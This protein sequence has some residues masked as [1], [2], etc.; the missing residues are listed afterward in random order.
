MGK[1]LQIGIA[2]LP[3]ILGGVI[4]WRAVINT[5]KRNPAYAHFLR[6]ERLRDFLGRYRFSAAYQI[7]SWVT[8]ID[9]GMHL[10]RKFQEEEQA[11]WKSGGLVALT[12]WTPSLKPLEDVRTPTRFIKV[13][14]RDGDTISASCLPENVADL[15]SVFCCI[16]NRVPI[17]PLTR[18]AGFNVEDIPCRLPDGS[19]VELDALQKWLNDGVAAGWSV[20]VACQYDPRGR[21]TFM[22]ATRQKTPAS[23][24][25]RSSPE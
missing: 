16:T 7:I 14:A 18:L 4:A 11:L 23:A 6:T 1:R 20:G 5:H 19:V 22:L 17:A 9:P 21:R 3:V 24:Q 2:I 25:A 12:F 8:G 10:R 13:F 15:Q